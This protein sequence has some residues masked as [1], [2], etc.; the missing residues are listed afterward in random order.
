MERASVL[1]AL[2][3]NDVND[4]ARFTTHGPLIDS[5]DPSTGLV[6]ARVRTCTRDDV[7]RA[8]VECERAFVALRALPAPRRGEMVRALGDALRTHK[9]ALGALVSME[10]GKILVEGQGEVQEMVDIA[11]FAVG[12]SRTLGGRTLPSERPMHRLF[13][14]WHPLGPVLVISAFNFPVS[15]WSWNAL[16]ALVCGDS[17][18]WKPSCKTP[19]V[20][21]AIQKIA[22]P[23]LARFGVPGAL[24]LCIG[25]DDVVGETLVRDA[26]YPLVSATGSTRMGR[27]VGAIVQERF[28]R[29]LLELGGNNALVVMDD[30]DLKLATRAILFGAVG[31]SG[32]RCTSTRRVLA[33]VDVIDLL[34]ENLRA[35]YTQVRIGDALDPRTLMGPLVDAD[36]VEMFLRN[37]D[38]AR[39]QGAVRVCGGTR[40]EG[41]P[42]G[43]SFVTPALL[44]SPR[45]LP[46]LREEV[47]APLLHI[48]SINSLDE[49]IAANNEVSHGLSSSIFT[50]DLR[51]AERFLAATGSDCGIANV[52]VGTNGAEI[53]GAFGG[54]KETG[55]GREAGSDAWKGYMRRQTCTVNYG[56]DLPL[57]QGITFGDD[58]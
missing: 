53:G 17:V 46:L 20:A 4:G 14:Q 18:L 33:H 25:P 49:A 42:A 9:N 35:A 2:G 24:S 50:R 7:E 26:R 12:L 44:R 6:I 37:L 47:F 41:M 32:Q 1:A 45:D 13:E 38:T 51:A 11:D 23:V 3:I 22:E 15:V 8:T 16:L 10:M 40:V 30:A 29:S 36:A 39:E 48:V 57:A 54:E 31:T 43:S 58:A 19:L 5:H 56:D 21:I 28:G 52:N 55:G 27:H 34:T